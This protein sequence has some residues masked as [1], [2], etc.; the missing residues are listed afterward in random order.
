MPC[1]SISKEK[2]QI[3]LQSTE[4]LLTID[5]TYELLYKYAKKEGIAIP[6]AM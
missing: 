5:P 1:D 2:K 4:L 3:Y 6:G